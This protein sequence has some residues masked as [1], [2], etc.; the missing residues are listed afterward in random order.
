MFSKP[1]GSANMSVYL[2]KGIHKYYTKIFVDST[3]DP[4]IGSGTTSLRNR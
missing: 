2:K 1:D 3:F 4:S